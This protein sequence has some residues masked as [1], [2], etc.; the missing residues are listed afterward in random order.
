MKNCVVLLVLILPVLS[1]I[2]AE[3]C[4]AQAGGALCPSG[5]CC[6]RWGWCGSTDVFCGEGCQGQ[7]GGGATPAQ[8]SPSPETS[9]SPPPPPASSGSTSD[10]IASIITPELF[11]Q[12][13]KHQNDSVCPSHGFYTY[14]AFIAAARSFSGF[15]TTGDITTRKRELAA[16]FG[17]TSHQTT[18]GWPGAPDGPYSWGYCTLKEQGNPPSY[19]VPSAQWPCDPAKSYYGRGPIHLSYNYNYGPCGQAIGQPLLA[20]PDLVI[21]DATTSFKTAVWFWMTAQGSKPS[22]HD[23]IVGR[24]TPS[25][26]DKAAGRFPGYGVITHLIN[27]GIECGKGPDPMGADRIGFYKKYC[28]LLGVSYGDNLDCYNQKPFS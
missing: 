21:T 4:G 12:M 6:S 27:G 25:A 15:G 7:C 5:Q 10:D 1:G 13:L 24:W 19:C 8:L 17:Q 14:D 18:G 20:N 23:V 9:P 2:S 22:C 3:Q 16:F 11:N 28:D 26:L